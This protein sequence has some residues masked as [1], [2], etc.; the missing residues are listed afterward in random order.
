MRRRAPIRHPEDRSTTR[1]ALV[2][3]PSEFG[4]QT[5][6]APARTIADR[7]GSQVTHDASVTS[8]VTFETGRGITTL[9]L[10]SPD[11]RNALSARL[12]D[13]LLAGVTRAVADPATRVI[14]LT[15]TG[16]TFCSGVDL[17]EAAG[18]A[19]GALDPVRHRAE[20]LATLLRAIVECPKPV[21]ARINGHARAGGT[22]LVA[23]CDIVIA[24]R[25]ATFALT[26][27]RLG[28][29]ASVA[30]LTVLPRLNGRAASS[31]LLT[32]TV[33]DGNE[34][35]RIGLITR[36]SDDVKAA[37][38][39]VCV[40]LAKCS[41]QGLRESKMLANHAVIAEFDRSAKR[42]I[43]HSTQLFHSEEAKEG[44]AAFLQRRAP[45]WA[46]P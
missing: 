37:A 2:G 3:R 42:L 26:E 6:R 40:S 45:R 22:G 28:L 18:D 8:C 23:A 31:M 24:G 41:T 29:A 25:D 21:V 39:E 11:N 44:M 7:K 15:H 38:A 46:R 10:N 9:T 19:D 14:V 30:S 43:D 13:E 16:G 1:I 35:A 4:M 5:Y 34:A 27:A 17:P 36:V 20:Q 33:I 32:G 12:A